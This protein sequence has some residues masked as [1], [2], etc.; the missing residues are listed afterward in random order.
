MHQQGQLEAAELA[1]RAILEND[2]RCAEA[3]HLFGL[4]ALARGEFTVA[5]DAIV[6]AVEL[7]STIAIYHYNLAHAQR[8][9]GALEDAIASYRRA[10]ELSP[11]DADIRNNLGTALLEAGDITGATTELQYA[12]AIAP[13]DA[14]IACTLGSVLFEQDRLDAAEECFHRALQAD[15]ELAEAENNLGAIAQTRGDNFTAFACYQR[16]IGLAPE[17]ASAHKNLASVMHLMQRTDD[18]IAHYREALRLQPDYA[19]AEYE[20]AA[21]LGDTRAAPPASYVAGVF[22]Q[23]AHEYDAHM[24]GVLGYGVPDKLRELLAPLLPQHSLDILDLG[25]GTGLSGE[26][27]NATANTLTGIDLSPKM[28]AK[29][30]E[31]GIYT[32]LIEGDVVAQTNQL[33]GDFDLIVAADVFVYLGDLAPVFAAVQRVLRPDGLF[34]FTVEHGDGDGFTVRDAGR[35]VHGTDY[36]RRIAQHA[37]LR[38]RAMT[39]TILRKDF[40]REINGA[41]WVFTLS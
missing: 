15:P 31:R 26:V 4:I 38:E 41:L 11:E 9:S 22:D 6:R 36:V 25:C 19:E 1:Y 16:A 34:A 21:L 28:L 7:D 10:R 37:G 8:Q 35:Y 24:T 32:T 20:L 18:A 39:E 27:F 5:L 30:R 40:G 17:F 12:H 3:W 14:Q 13:N 23:Y 29:A 33:S 2:A